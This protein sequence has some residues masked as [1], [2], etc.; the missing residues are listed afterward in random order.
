MIPNRIQLHYRRLA[1]GQSYELDAAAAAARAARDEVHLVRGQG[2]TGQ[3]QVGRGV[4]VLIICL[5]GRIRVECNDGRF[6]L[7]GRELLALGGESLIAADARSASDWLLLALSGSLLARTAR[8]FTG[9]VATDPVLFTSRER[10]GRPLLGG[11]INLLRRLESSPAMATPGAG[12]QYLLDL[13]HHAIDAQAPMGGWVERACGRSQRHRR[14][15]VAR[16]LRAR[17]RMLNAP[18]ER[19]ALDDLALASRYSKSHFIR[20]FKDVFGSTPHDFLSTVRVERA[21][22]LILEGRMAIAEVACSVGFESRFAFSR[23]FKQR[24]G[25]SAQEYRQHT[26]RPVTRAA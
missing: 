9:Q 3:V 25:I 12:G 20:L 14:Q 4:Q 6:Q 7:K 17:N 1:N 11:A 18:F 22:T 2:R 8:H 21:K 26:P 23:L 19:H 13:L 10:V 16:L 24:V 15:V 5:R